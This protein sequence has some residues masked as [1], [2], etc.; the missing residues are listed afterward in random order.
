MVPKEVKITDDELERI[1]NILKD[2]SLLS[3]SSKTGSGRAAAVIQNL[4]LLRTDIILP[5]LYERYKLVVVVMENILL[6]LSVP[7]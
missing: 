4:A 1:V 3:V 2:V 7:R 6:Y 5:P